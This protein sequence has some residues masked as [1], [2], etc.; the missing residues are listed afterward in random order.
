MYL[1]KQEFK[2]EIA[3]IIE[4]FVSGFVDVMYRKFEEEETTSKESTVKSQE[5]IMTAKEVC[6]YYNFHD[7]T[8][9]RREA[10]GLKRMPSHK[11]KNRM[12]RFTECERFFNQKK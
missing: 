1:S 12:F 4:A 8:L 5:K 2:E 9:R 3:P 10:E 11:Y 6:E 7:S